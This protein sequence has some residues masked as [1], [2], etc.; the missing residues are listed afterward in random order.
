MP[1][2]PGR[3]AAQLQEAL[4]HHRAGRLAE[5]E[6]L[7]K[8]VLQSAPEQPD[9]LRLLA[10]IA[11][12]S[13]RHSLAETFAKRAMAVRPDNAELHRILAAALME[14]GKPAAA[15]Q[16]AKRALE[17]DPN[18]A[19]ARL[20]LGNALHAAAD[21]DG[22]EREW[23][24]VLAVTPADVPTQYNLAQLLLKTGRNA[25]ARSLLEGAVAKAPSHA[26][27][28]A[29]LG[30][31]KVAENPAQ[32]A[33]LLQRAIELG[34]RSAEIYVSLG[35]ALTEL[36]NLF[37]ARG[38]FEEALRLSPRSADASVGLAEICKALEQPER[39][40]QVL[41]QA[42]VANPDNEQIRGL[43]F[44]ALDAMW[45]MDEGS[46]FA[47]NYVAKSAKFGSS[48]CRYANLMG[49]L[50]PQEVFAVHRDWGSR[51][52]DPLGATAEPHANRADPDRK[53]RVGYVSGDF[54]RH[55]V[56][57]FLLPLLGSHDRRQID[58]CLYNNHKGKKDAVTEQLRGLSDLWRDIDSLDDADAAA[59]IRADAIDILI[60]LS[61]H[62]GGHRLQMFAHRPAPMQ[63]SYLG[64]IDTT[65]MLAMDYR[66]TDAIVD[67]PG[68]ADRFNLEK[69]IR[70][71]GGY[72][73]YQPLPVDIAPAPPPVLATGYITFGSSNNIT[74]LTKEA[75]ALWAAILRRVPDSRLLLKDWRFTSA[76]VRLAFAEVFKAAGI[77]KDRLDLR[78]AT[79]GDLE[80][81]QTYNEIDIALDPFP[82]NG[83]TTTCEALWMGVP[84]VALAGQRSV[85]RHGLDILSRIGMT[86]LVAADKA[87]YA[88]IAVG[89]AADSA[90]LATLRQGLRGKLLASPLCDG[91]RLAREMEAAYRMAWRHWCE[92]TPRRA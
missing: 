5:A 1:I 52:A 12:Q 53:L 69:L 47:R 67:P 15:A 41:K 51:F 10:G 43:I 39:G 14:R 56:A 4:A 44:D 70:I 29:L 81:L 19:P 54:R 84:V 77:D 28:L 17:L 30:Q 33:S 68:E 18:F 26:G 64:Y 73:C 13:G 92:A 21:L 37:G 24:A 62:T 45:R 25:E 7:Y 90:A 16:S 32:A 60:D 38:A 55:S 87:G 3:I 74:K 23:R 58:V 71:E 88:D 36:K 76:E 34:N 89:L 8:R 50:A 22:A 35:D 11:L 49:D 85:S 66:I 80:H 65:G 72:L 63:M 61:G 57:A 75:L 40:L 82:Y 83:V 79:K 2:D 42:L 91:L 20:L 48:L 27:A 59:L 86:E 6:R 9:A 31:S 46:A 78:P